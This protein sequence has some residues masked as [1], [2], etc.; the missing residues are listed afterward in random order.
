MDSVFDT[1]IRFFTQLPVDW[2]VIGAF[3]II[4]AFDCL[5]SGAKRVSTL[6][7]ALPAAALVF[8]VLQNAAIIGDISRQFSSPVL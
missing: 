5:R 4:A 3:V 2:I 7:L 1:V 6:A 8:S